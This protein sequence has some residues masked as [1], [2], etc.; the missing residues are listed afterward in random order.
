M[1]SFIWK[2]AGGKARVSLQYDPTCPACASRGQIIVGLK[3][4]SIGEV[5]WGGEQKTP[6]PS[7]PDGSTFSTWNGTLDIPNA[8]GTYE[9]C[10]LRVPG[11]DANAALAEA[12]AKRFDGC[13]T[14]GMALV[15][16]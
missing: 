2:R 1:G 16:A 4:Q 12:K 15:G 13:Q 3:G 6:N 8:P 5:V 9:I 7:G 10:V 14:I 11:A